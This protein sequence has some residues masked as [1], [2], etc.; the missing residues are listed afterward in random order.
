MILTDEEIRKLQAQHPA[1]NDPL[2]LCRT[3][4]AAVLAKLRE[5]EPVAWTI[6]LGGLCTH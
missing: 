4:E 2:P 6:G 3:I 1:E 5:Q